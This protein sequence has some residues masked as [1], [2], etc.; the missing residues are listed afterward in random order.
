M[1]LAPE[2]MRYIWVIR[3]GKSA[4]AQPGQRDHERPLNKRGER[5]GKAM[6]AWLAQQ[7]H[8]AQWVWSSTAVRAKLTAA[9]VTG[10]FNA[11]F[12]EEA[13]LYL[14]SAEQVLSCLRATPADVNSVAVVA[15][16]PG[17]THLVN[18]LGNQRVT[19]N[20]VTFGTAL[21]STQ[22]NWADLSFGCAQ[23]LQL[24]TP[25]LLRNQT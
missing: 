3:H 21:F 2:G 4:D 15:H 11:T 9:Y 16:N 10:A 8:C 19:D 1:G 14:S 23:L 18:L 13:S 20:L 12:V 25:K 7:E 24:Q 5:D 6:Q 22:A 17:L